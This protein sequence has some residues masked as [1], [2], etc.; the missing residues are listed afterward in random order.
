MRR[1]LVFGFLVPV[2]LRPAFAEETWETD[3]AKAFARA[4][5]EG[6]LA[7]MAFAGSD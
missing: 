4:K 1:I 7:L 6:S 3:A 5:Q 2:F